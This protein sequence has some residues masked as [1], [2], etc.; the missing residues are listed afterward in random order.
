MADIEHN[1][2]A[3]H[4]NKTEDFTNIEHNFLCAENIVYI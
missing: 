1:S 4:N 3:C 2:S